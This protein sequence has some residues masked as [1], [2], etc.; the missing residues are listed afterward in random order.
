VDKQQ[1]DTDES[2]V[3]RSVCYMKGCSKVATTSARLIINKKL[4][5]VV[6][7]CNSCLPSVSGDV[8]SKM[9]ANCELQNNP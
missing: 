9:G 2:K 4:E 7:V 1:Y 6:Y 8:A 5:L 3:F